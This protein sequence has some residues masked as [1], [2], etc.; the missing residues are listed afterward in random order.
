MLTCTIGVS[1]RR[2]WASDRKAA[3]YRR[4]ALTAPLMVVAHLQ[5][6]A[7][8]PQRLGLAGLG[9]GQE[10]PADGD[11]VRQQTLEDSCILPEQLSLE[12]LELAP[13][14]VPSGLVGPGG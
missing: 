6:A 12:L 10:Q 7:S 1:S 13:D 11:A 5:G 9:V 14:R 2:T 8:R 3:R 4:W